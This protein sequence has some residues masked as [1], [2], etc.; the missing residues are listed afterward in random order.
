MMWAALGTGQHPGTVLRD[1]FH[2]ARRCRARRRPSTMRELEGLEPASRIE[3]VGLKR[4]AR[5]RR[6]SKACASG[7]AILVADLFL[8]KRLDMQKYIVAHQ[9]GTR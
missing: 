1:Y 3:G 6:R 2:A 8:Y 5:F 9:S 4:R 7:G